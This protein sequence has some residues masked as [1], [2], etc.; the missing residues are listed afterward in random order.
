MW[1]FPPGAGGYCSDGH[2]VFEGLGFYTTAI[3]FGF[4]LRR[5]QEIPHTKIHYTRIPG[6][7]LCGMIDHLILPDGQNFQSPAAGGSDRNGLV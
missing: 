5:R 4:I 6:G 2:L 7:Q 3:C 1:T